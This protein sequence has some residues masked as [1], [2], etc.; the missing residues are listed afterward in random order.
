MNQINA[1]VILKKNILLETDARIC[2]LLATLL[3][4]DESL[5]STNGLIGMADDM[6]AGLKRWV[7]EEDRVPEWTALRG[8]RARS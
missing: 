2:H 8:L 4:E 6:I 3:K 5:S 7:C 1:Q